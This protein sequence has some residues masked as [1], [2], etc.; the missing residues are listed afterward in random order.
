MLLK[1]QTKQTP[2]AI[3]VQQDDYCSVYQTDALDVVLVGQIFNDLQNFQNAAHYFYITVVNQPEQKI[4]EIDGYYGVVVFYKASASIEVFRDPIGMQPLYYDTENGHYVFSSTLKAIKEA[5]PDAAPCEEFFLKC[6]EEITPNTHEL[7]MYEGI[8][9]IV[10]NSKY[11]FEEGKETKKRKLFN[12]ENIAIQNRT[13]EEAIKLFQEKLEKTIENRIKGHN[14][15]FFQYTGG[16]DST[17]ILAVTRFLRGNTEGFH[18]Y[19]HQ[20]FPDHQSFDEMHIVKKLHHTE[21]LPL[22]HYTPETHFETLQE[23]VA[24][25]KANHTFMLINQVLDNIY[26][27]INNKKGKLLFSGFGGDEG[28]TF[29]EIPR[30]FVNQL[31]DFRLGKA[32]QSISVYGTKRYLSQLIKVDLRMLLLNTFFPNKVLPNHFAFRKTD[33]SKELRKHVYDTHGY[34]RYL[35]S[36]PRV[37]YRIEE[38]KEMAASYGVVLAYPWLDF[39]VLRFFLSLKENQLIYKRRGR[40]FYKNALKKYIQSDWYFN[41]RKSDSV[42]F[43]EPKF[44][45]EG[46]L[47]AQLINQYE[48]L[49]QF[50]K[51][52][53]FRDSLPKQHKIVK[54]TLLSRVSKINLW[55]SHH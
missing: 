46:E 42:T 3:L 28:I 11:T 37:A 25:G 4:D 34:I 6:L 47:D 36:L 21:G 20:Y 10:P 27:D 38:E 17:G 12:F 29:N 54:E 13:D 16:L 15:L 35:L 30:F 48:L 41:Y 18:S 51:Q 31:R 39:Q 55:L 49:P 32:I 53:N 44:K 8:V 5:L 43:D 23:E 22:P 24:Y 14:E 26:I 52:Y 2:H 19:I 7:T 33:K 1:I 45:E 50:I 9:R 40:L